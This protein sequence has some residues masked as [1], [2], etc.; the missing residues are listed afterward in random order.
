[1]TARRKK[2]A[3][4]RPKRNRP[5]TTFTLSEEARDLL[6]KLAGHL[7]LS[8]SATVEFLIRQAARREGVTLPER[9]RRRRR[10]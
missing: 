5:L 6:D 3:A 4:G 9:G 10:V 2:A 1:M 7:G 8:R